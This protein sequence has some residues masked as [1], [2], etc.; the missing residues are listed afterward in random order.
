MKETNELLVFLTKI[1]LKTVENQKDGFQ[2][3]DLLTYIEN[4]TDAP[5]A[6]GGLNKI[7]PEF[8]EAGVADIEGTAKL[9]EDTIKNE[10]PQIDTLLLGTLVSSLKTLLST[11]ALITKK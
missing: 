2:L 4:I 7:K 9:I 1:I 10:Y 11:Y 3:S 5:A 8:I 6:F